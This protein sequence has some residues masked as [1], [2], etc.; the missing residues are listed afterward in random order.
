MFGSDGVDPN[1]GFHEWVLEEAKSRPVIQKALDL[2]INFFDTANIYS[3]GAS[4]KILGQALNDFAKRNGIV[5]T[6]KAYMKMK[7]AP[8]SG[9]YLGKFCFIKLTKV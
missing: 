4:E 9:G 7:Q 6:T 3:Y 5:V 8:N 1:S 2:G